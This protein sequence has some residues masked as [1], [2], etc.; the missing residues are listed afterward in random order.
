MVV[1]YAQ[2]KLNP[3]QAMSAAAVGG[4]LDL[5]KINLETR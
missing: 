4:M 5:K 2:D 3:V 1:D